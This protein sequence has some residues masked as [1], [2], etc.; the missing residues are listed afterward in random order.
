M[1]VE[2]CYRNRFK[3]ASKGRVVLM[4]SAM[5]SCFS[6]GYAAPIGG[7]VTTGSA[8]IASNGTTTNITQSTQK[9]SINWQG[10]SI[11]SNETVNFN[12]PSASAITLNRVVGNETSV[13]AGALNANGKVF[14]LNSNGI[15]FTQGSSV[16]T[17]GLVASTLNLS[18]EDFNNNHF[19]FQGNGSQ[20]SV[21]NMGT[22]TIA[23]SGYAALLGK[24]VSNQGVI[25]ATKGVVAFSSGD[26]ITL[27]FNGD[28]LMSVTIDE[29]TLNALV[30]NKNAIYA[31]GGKVI[32]TA[33]AANDLL[34]SQV[35]NEGLIQAQTLDDLKG[36]ITLYAH[37]GT[38]TVSG[39]LDASAPTKGD[40]G[41]IE[42]SGD[43]VA[44][45]DSTTIT[46][47][48]INGNNG[49]WLI[50]PTNFT[51]AYGSGGQTTSSIGA[52]T[53]Q[54]ALGNGNVAITTA[55]SGTEAGDININADVTWTANNTLTLTALG[56]INAN[57]ALTWSAGTLALNAGKN[58]NVNAT[59]TAKLA[60]NLVANWGTGTNSDGSPYGLYMLQR[61]WDYTGFIGSINFGSTTTGSVTLNGT[62][63]TVIRKLA[64][65]S[66]INNDPSG[67]YV[68]GTN[69][70]VSDTGGITS[71]IG[72]S[73]PFTGVLEGLGHT[74][75][76]G[77]DSTTGLGFV[78]SGLF[79]TIGVGG[80][81]RNLGVSGTINSTTGTVENL[82][83]IAN[84]NQGTLINVYSGSTFLSTQN[85]TNVGGMV[86]LNEGTIILGVDMASP[87]ASTIAGGLVGTNMGLITLSIAT[88]NP[89]YSATGATGITYVGGLVGVNYGAITQS[90]SDIYFVLTDTT[91]IAGGLV[92]LNAGTIDQSYAARNIRYT[93]SGP[94]LAG[95]VGENTG[96]ITNSYSTLFYDDPYY[97]GTTR[98]SWIAGFA[99]K[100][101]GTISNSYATSYAYDTATHAGF[102]YDNTGGTTTNDYWYAGLSPTATAYG[103]HSTA[104]QLTAEQA[105][106]FSSYA[107]FS[108]DVWAKSSSGYAV[109][110][111]TPVYILSG[112]TTT[113]GSALALLTKGLQGGGGA[114]SLV[115][116]FG[117][118]K[119]APIYIID[120]A[121]YVDA[122]N[123]AAASVLDSTIYNTMRGLVMVSQK[124]LTF[125]D[126]SIADKTYDGTTTAT[127]GNV[128]LVG[129]VGDQ[130]LAVSGLTGVFSNANAGTDK[131]VTI[132]AG[133]TL[134][135]GSNGGKASNYKI[136]STTTTATITPKALSV[137]TDA[138][139]KVYDGT[140]NA[141]VS[142][143]H[144]SGIVSGDTVLLNSYTAAF[145]DKNVGTDKSVTFSNAILSGS[146]ATNYTISS[147]P[148][149]TTADITPRAVEL[150][151]SKL[152]DSSTTV[153]ASQLYVK[154]AVAGDSVS[155]S[156]T[157]NI[158]GSTSGT[159]TITNTSGLSVNNANY[160]IVGSV[161]SVLVGG[162]SLAL[163]K[164]ASGTANITTDGTTT[165]VTTSD[166]AVLDWLRFSIGSSET[167]KFVQP[168]ST[169]IVLNRVTGNEA[170]IIAGILNANGK[171]F[172]INSN[173]VVFKA[174]SSVNASSLVASTLN[175][176]NSDFL[177]GN[178]VFSSTGGTGSVIEEGSIVI[179]D[180]GFLAMASE[181]GVS[182]KGFIA[183]P[184]GKSILASAKALTLNLDATTGTLDNYEV[185]QL[186][187][188]TTLNGTVSLK[189]SATNPATL[190]TAGNTVSLGSNFALISELSDTWSISLP[191]IIIG[192]TT[193]N[194]TGSWINA[195][196]ASLNLS[197]NAL[198]SNIT[199]NEA[200]HWS[201]DSLLSLSAL[202]DIYI[203]KSITATGTNAGLV[204]NYGGDYHVLTKASYSGTV[205]D[206]NGK[207]VANVAPEGT[208][209]ASITL[210]GSNASLKINGNSYTLI[211]SVDQLDA[212]DQCVNGL[213]YNPNTG[214]YS[215]AGISVSGTKAISMTKA[216]NNKFWNPVTQAYD[217]DLTKDINGV[218]Y[219]Y[220]L[221]TG[222]YDLTS[223]YAGK[224]Q[225]Y[226]YDPTTGKYTHA[227]YNA[228]TSVQKYWNPTT[229][230][231]DLSSSYSGKLYYDIATNQYDKFSYDTT[232]KKYYNQLTGLYDLTSAKTI[233][234]LYYNTSTGKY[235]LTTLPTVSGYYALASDLD[236]SGKTYAAS[237]LY[238]LSGTLAG[239]GHTISNLTISS[240][241]P[242]ATGTLYKGMIDYAQVGSI[243]RDI[244]LINPVESF[245]AGTSPNIWAGSLVGMLYGSLDQVYVE[246]GSMTVP[247]GSTGG[248][249]ANASNATIEDSYSTMSGVTGGL[250]ARTS[251][252]SVI[253]SHT[254]GSTTT[255][256]LIAAIYN[257]T[258]IAND[259]A[260][261]D[262]GQGGLIGSY[263]T[264][265]GYSNTIKDSFATGDINGAG[266]IGG[267]LGAQSGT[268][269]L[270][271]Y[272][273]YA[274]GNVNGSYAYQITTDMGLGIGGLVG[275]AEAINI[276]NSYAR[277][278][279]TTD[280]NVGY[281]GG[282]VGY[283]SGN[284]SAPS[285][286]TNSYALGNV[287]SNGN[288]STY[289]SIGGLVGSMS[290]TTITG[291]YAKG[292]VTGYNVVGG[293]V[294]SASN[295]GIIDSYTTGLITATKGFGLNTS[296]G[297]IVA[298]GSF[299][300][301]KNSYYNS[302]LNANRVM[303][304]YGNPG[305]GY[306]YHNASTGLT[307]AQMGDVSAYANG[308]IT[309]VLANRATTAAQAKAILE[310]R[311]E[312]ANQQAENI[313]SISR[314][315]S[316]E[317]VIKEAFQEVYAQNQTLP[318]SLMQNIT[319]IDPSYTAS[320]KTIIIDGKTYVVDDEDEITK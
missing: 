88:G 166:K 151:G 123:S 231:Y 74:V 55:S 1:Y 133:Y 272:N 81:V 16:N 164:V 96:T 138:A 247:S 11:A 163:D 174:G 234:T 210:S 87:Y 188:T 223:F 18:D 114:Y 53:L 302:E 290:Y 229:N 279:V 187:G 172:I 141:T 155:V 125:A 239:L 198:S 264:A 185:R 23:N 280:A 92:G 182:A 35:N 69:V 190:E 59:L 85:V 79:D 285:S 136:T 269:A 118:D 199:L 128:S 281:V 170:T 232:T 244:G 4:V 262:S 274:K 276:V 9:A 169:S 145:I 171:V 45:V 203:N 301:L 126:G 304:G 298:T 70:F 102:V 222:A 175:I 101:S 2:K 259:Y 8:T 41:F 27:N 227:S 67:H 132:N 286:I 153:N 243:V 91:S 61:V 20:G 317:K 31:D 191:S 230:Q 263:N 124:T 284:S 196:L 238:S 134:S 267:L 6:V 273:S 108:S 289:N 293:L 142:N 139:D 192:G 100:N 256:G 260:T 86:G 143:A 106:N 48:S 201:S 237:L 37:G 270:N 305:F 99:Y 42:T 127:A 116:N 236:A 193:G 208:E 319:I 292:N 159:Q 47:K 40:G 78:G 95:F 115:D 161:G 56:D 179:V 13:I 271:I 246:G 66:Q 26:K 217:I 19:V 62:P 283:I 44:I 252:G 137:T 257:G 299:L 297:G 265:S 82:G 189:S 250:V 51:I 205:Y 89:I 258:L 158:A 278:D 58:I 310:Q 233:S 184:G 268:P 93:S 122:G 107:G 204:M 168:S 3:I 195:R 219:N 105:A 300:T 197:L 177:S 251:G 181:N 241:E 148:V 178:Y 90:W 200:I 315:A 15:L 113:Y 225:S 173:G 30:E 130:T 165:T 295:S 275:S 253:R 224:I 43:K 312:N 255:G 214:T 111:N 220:N 25:V 112:S 209:Y 57:A 245:T 216:S 52:T 206:A 14:L 135:D 303:G 277:G 308:T 157:V 64:D 249:V 215:S 314:R 288:A 28:S 12:Q 54:N 71:A 131:T 32:L 287:I 183:T 147:T 266:Q 149:A 24:E 320:I 307:N 21:I 83:S 202:S 213:C 180:G 221:D 167:L 226:F 309:Q 68:L 291:S 218:T 120:G 73:T 94:H 17:S 207:L 313:Q 228:D 306:Y 212:L 65:L 156:G 240:S 76:L 242:L 103:D 176:S 160:T 261:G 311:V 10:F 75:Y 121:A 248:L 63:Y 80:V 84:V 150:Y 117:D 140:T 235:D 146:S 162:S 186:S 7:V 50:D 254:T 144:L 294:G 5:L 72:S 46:T 77:Y 119:N 97:I 104:K 152:A 33:K 38:T 36:E 22:I 110:K 194:F 282:L 296:V 39:T 98:S 49:T 109:L 318:I 154:N 29:G 60:G 34:A 316:E 211:H 129:L